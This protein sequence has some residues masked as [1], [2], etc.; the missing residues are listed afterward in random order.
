M[1]DIFLELPDDLMAVV[2]R[3]ASILGK[4]AED[5]LRDVIEASAPLDESDQTPLAE[6]LDCEPIVQAAEIENEYRRLG[7]KFGWRFIT[8]PQDNADRAKLLLV[9]LNPAGRAIHGPSWSQEKGSAYRVESWN[10][11]PPATSGLQRQVQ[12]LFAFLGLRDSEVFSAH[13]IPFRSPSWAELEHKSEAEALARRLWTR[14]KDKVRFERIVCIGKDRPG[15]PIADL[16]EA[17]YERGMATGWGNITADRYRLPDGR[18]LIALPHLSRFALF[19]RA[20]GERE[21]RELFEL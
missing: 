15:R 11:L 12:Q 8:C 21:L 18:P 3:R 9:S 1:A 2:E 20:R 13:Y 16:F 7:Y 17:S 4:T 10:G 6:T 14:L 5:F 19:G